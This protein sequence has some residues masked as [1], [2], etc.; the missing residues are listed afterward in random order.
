MKIFLD[1]CAYIYEVDA[2]IMSIP[3]IVSD[4]PNN[5]HPPAVEVDLTGPTASDLGNTVQTKR[6]YTPI[7]QGIR[8]CVNYAMQ[9]LSGATLSTWNFLLG[10]FP[11]EA[12]TSAPSSKSAA[13]NEEP[14]A[15]EPTGST[16]IDAAAA[17][18]PLPDS[19]T[20]TASEVVEDIDLRIGLL[21]YWDKGLEKTRESAQ[22][23]IDTHVPVRVSLRSDSFE[24]LYSGTVQESLANL[25]RLIDEADQM[26]RR[27]QQKIE[28]VRRGESSYINGCHSA[29]IELDTRISKAVT[30]FDTV[31][32]AKGRM[33]RFRLWEIVASM[34]RSRPENVALADAGSLVDEAREM[35]ANHAI[36]SSALRSMRSDLAS[37][38]T[39]LH[40]RLE[41]AIGELAELTA[42]LRELIIVAGAFDVRNGTIELF[43][44]IVERTKSFQTSSVAD[45]GEYAIPEVE[46]LRTECVDAIAVLRKTLSPC[47]D[48]LSA[49]KELIRQ[50]WR[51]EILIDRNPY[52]EGVLQLRALCDSA[53]GSVDSG[54]TDVQQILDT[55]TQIKEEASIFSADPRTDIFDKLHREYD[56]SREALATSY[57]D[58][59]PHSGGTLEAEKRKFLKYL[60]FVKHIISFPGWNGAV[61]GT[62]EEIICKLPALTED[63][64]RARTANN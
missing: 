7:W 39:E 15:D 34:D 41:V 12:G 1:K 26:H 33:A 28:A 20:A 32:S 57:I 14:P 31:N 19:E 40:N 49:R 10:R 16:P 44:H 6:F 22:E 21:E 60:A 36:G 24:L 64:K 13:A 11:F 42:E 25:Q 59:T 30:A 35:V 5:V 2:L 9:W 56:R 3:V 58:S 63:F 17:D 52:I 18:A 8:Y 62:A 48:V 55:I 27:I 43:E 46:A 51:T 37:I 61:V 50:L 4:A 54:C 38:L 53:K 23:I 29:I 45:L 47:A